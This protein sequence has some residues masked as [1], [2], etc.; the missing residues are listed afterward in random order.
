MSRTPDAP[1]EGLLAA[2]Q[3]GEEVYSRQRIDKKHERDYSPP[4]HALFLLVA[5]IRRKAKSRKRKLGYPPLGMYLILTIVFVI[6]LL[7]FPFLFCLWFVIKVFYH[8]EHWLFE[9]PWSCPYCF[10]EHYEHFCYCPKCKTIEASLYPVLGEFLWRR[11]SQCR[12]SYF[13]L[14]GRFGTPPHECTICRTVMEDTGCRRPLPTDVPWGQCPEKHIG[15]CGPTSWKKLAVLAMVWRCIQEGA[16]SCVGEPIGELTQ[17]E[18]A[19]VLATLDEKPKQL[20]ESQKDLFYTLSR[21]GLFHCQHSRRKW[22]I[23]F[24]NMAN[25]WFKSDEKLIEHGFHL[26]HDESLIFVLDPEHS[27]VSQIGIAPNAGVYSRLIRCIEEISLDHQAI[28]CFRGRVAIV[29]LQTKHAT[30]ELVETR[31]AWLREF[32]P[33]LWGLLE[34]T[35]KGRWAFFSGPVASGDESS[36][37]ISDLVDYVIR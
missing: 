4:S 28:K 1:D 6:D 17:L 16:A 20:R 19:Y 31:D 13:Q 36:K 2:L 27:D 18:F 21:S 3:F 11:C 12:K 23:Q 8:L 37:W 26:F 24:H 29:L 5:W 7:L 15:I 32:D 33:Q 34:H 10:T 30:D 9:Y 22:L 14:W 25:R 35:V